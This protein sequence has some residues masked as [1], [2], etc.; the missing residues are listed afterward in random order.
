MITVF[1]L[2]LGRYTYMR[3]LREETKVNG[4]VV[5]VRT[6]L[7]E[8]DYEVNIPYLNI[9]LFLFILRYLYFLL[10]LTHELNFSVDVVLNS[11]RSQ[12]STGVQ[13]QKMLPVEKPVL[14]T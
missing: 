5:E 6:N 13:D 2:L 14:P 8:K 12:S 3:T 11:T 4:Q 9:F 10:L 7:V 1:P